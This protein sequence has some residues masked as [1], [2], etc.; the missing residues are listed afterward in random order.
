MSKRGLDNL[1]GLLVIVVVVVV[2]EEEEETPSGGRNLQ[3]KQVWRN[4]GLPARFLSLVT[5]DMQ[6]WREALLC[7]EIGHSRQLHLVV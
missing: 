4:P 3:R 6:G 5:I 1:P 2:V 7:V